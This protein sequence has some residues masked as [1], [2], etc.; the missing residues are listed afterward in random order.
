MRHLDQDARQIGRDLSGTEKFA[1][2]RRKCRKVEM[3]F[4]Y[5]KRNRGFTRLW[6]RGLRGAND[7]CIHAATAQNLKRLAK[8]VPA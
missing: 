3:L 5:L 7:E 1:V 4:A 6:L 2:S 8:L